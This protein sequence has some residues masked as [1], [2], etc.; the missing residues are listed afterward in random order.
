MFILASKTHV[1]LFNT[2]VVGNMNMVLYYLTISL[3]KHASVLLLVIIHYTLCM[4]HPSK[5]Y[6]CTT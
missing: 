1:G 5:N 2:H 4:Y 3:H 6:A